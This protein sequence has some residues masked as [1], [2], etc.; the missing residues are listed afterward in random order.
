MRHIDRE[1][2]KAIEENLK[3]QIEARKTQPTKYVY[4]LKEDC[5]KADSCFHKLFFKGHKENDTVIEVLNPYLQ[6]ET[7]CA[8]YRTWGATQKLAAGFTRQVYAMDEDTRKRF[9]SR[10]MKVICKTVY[11]EMRSGQHLLS[12]SDQLFIRKC[13]K[14]VGWNFPEDGFNQMFIVPAW[15]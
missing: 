10:C 12:P 15:Y 9:Q 14:E 3:R 4:C 1:K 7:E 2:Q 6:N 8:H 11:Y 5:P 13:A